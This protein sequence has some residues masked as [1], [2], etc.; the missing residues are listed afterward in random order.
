[1]QRLQISALAVAVGLH[2]KRL[3]RAVLLANAIELIDDDVE[4][5]IPTDAL[6]AAAAVLLGVAARGLDF[7]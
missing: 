5:L 6:V 7:I 2:E 4:H 1:M 3:H